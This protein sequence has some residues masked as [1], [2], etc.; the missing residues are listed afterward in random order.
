MAVREVI[1][2]GHPTLR[3]K[4]K[5]LTKEEILS[6]ETKEFVQDLMETMEDYEGIGIAAPQVGVSKQLAII[7]VPDDNPRYPDAPPSKIYVVINPKISVLDETLQGYWEGCLS[8]PGLRGH[9][10]RPR[11]IRLDFMDLEARQ[12]TIILEGFLATVFQHELDHLDGV[13]YIDRIKDT[14]KLS[15]NEEFAQFYGDDEDEID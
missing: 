2:M 1:R 3:L 10:E 6:K 5:A 14:K 7:G 15:Y 13:L 4:A 8:V 11:K 9:V 12:N